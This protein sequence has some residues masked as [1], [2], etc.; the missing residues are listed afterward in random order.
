[1]EFAGPSFFRARLTDPKDVE[2][3]TFIFY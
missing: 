3:T 1:V 2:T